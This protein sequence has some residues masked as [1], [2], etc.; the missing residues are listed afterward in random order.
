MVMV[1]QIVSLLK[2]IELYIKW[3]N[4]MVCELYFNKALWKLKLWEVRYSLILHV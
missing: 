4:S 3:V 2:A 1:T